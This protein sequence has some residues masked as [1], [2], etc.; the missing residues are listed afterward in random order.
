M[1]YN[2]RNEKVCGQKRQKRQKR[3]RLTLNVKV[4]NSLKKKLIKSN[5]CTTTTLGIQKYWPLLVVDQRLLYA[6]KIGNVRCSEVPLLYKCGKRNSNRV[7]AVDRW[8]LFRGG[9]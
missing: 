7:V 8:K 3:Y 2:V 4:K 1:V 9:R 5:L 6:L